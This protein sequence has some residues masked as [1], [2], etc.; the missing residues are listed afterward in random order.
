[1][2]KTR[3]G[4]LE[5]AYKDLGYEVVINKEKPR[6]G[7]FV[8]TIDGDETPIIEMLNL[9][10]PFAKLRAFDIEEFITTLK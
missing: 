10:R 8:V 6:K 9:A 5:K 1:V 3:A 2:F 7:S 4:K